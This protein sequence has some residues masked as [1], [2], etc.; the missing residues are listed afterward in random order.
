MARAARAE[1]VPA[2]RAELQAWLA[3]GP[4][5]RTLR[6][7]RGRAGVERA[8][9]ARELGAAELVHLGEH[10]AAAITEA[11]PTLPGWYRMRAEDTPTAAGFATY[12]RPPLVNGA[13]VRAGVWWPRRGRWT[14]TLWA[15]GERGLEET[16]PAEQDPD[17]LART[18]A[19]LVDIAA[20]PVPPPQRADPATP[21]AEAGE[22]VRLI[23]AT[24]LLLAQDRALDIAEVRG[25]RS[26]RLAIAVD[27]MLPP[28][29]AVRAVEL[30]SPAENEHQDVEDGAGPRG[31]WR[32]QR[33]PG[34]P[35]GTRRP[36]W[37]VNHQQ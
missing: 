2:A 16:A 37:V 22:A 4:G 32:P 19:R 24:W 25:S 8:R 20:V 14:V 3:A 15:E 23:V 1:Y 31:W 26:V 5:P 27:G 11:T 33:G 9:A 28:E 10:L 36:W 21:V 30:R 18:P 29:T 34:G 7:G 6:P 12:A 17:E 13:P 35:V